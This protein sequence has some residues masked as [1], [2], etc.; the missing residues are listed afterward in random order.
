MIRIGVL[1]SGPAGQTLA[2]GFL[3]HGHSVMIGSRDPSKLR[4][5]L[6]HAG[7]QARIGTFAETAQF[8]ELV[9]GQRQS[10]GG[11]DPHYRH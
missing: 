2:T 9:V 3:S 6:D 1:G 7:S 8:G 10:C 11:R 5:W 4:D